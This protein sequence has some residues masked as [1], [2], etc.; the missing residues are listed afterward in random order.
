MR[1][2]YGAVKQQQKNRALLGNTK[3]TLDNRSV[4]ITETKAL[5]LILLS[6]AWWAWLPHPFVYTM[7]AQYLYR[8]TKLPSEDST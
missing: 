3:S 1:T 2:I 7:Q 8:A 6:I 4:G 5:L